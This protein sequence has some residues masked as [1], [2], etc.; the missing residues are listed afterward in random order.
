[1]TGART[2]HHRCCRH[3]HALRHR[4]RHMMAVGRA[5]E[6]MPRESGAGFAIVWTAGYFAAAVVDKGW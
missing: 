3:H 6:R 1:M 2:H 4:S 5:S